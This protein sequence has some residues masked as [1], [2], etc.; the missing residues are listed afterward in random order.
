[1]A[2]SATAIKLSGATEILRALGFRERQANE[3]AAYT[4]LALLDLDPKKPWSAASNPLRGI[5]PIIDFLSKNYRVRYAPNTR[6]TIRDEAVKYFVNA[7][8]LLRNPDDAARPTN[9]GKTVYQIEPAALALIH[10]YG[11]VA[12]ADNLQ[13]YL[14]KREQIIAGVAKQRNL[15]RIPVKL[16]LGKSITLSPGG[17]N[18]LIK[19][20]IEEFC[21][22]FSPGGTVV[23]IG[24]TES[25]FL[26]YDATYLKNLGVIVAPAAKMPDVIVHDTRRNWLLL[27]EAVTSAGPVDFKRRAELKELFG[28]CK[29][30]LVFVTA[31]ENRRAMQSFAA[32]I[33]WESEV[34]IADN[35]DH[36]VHFNGER[37][38]GPYPDATPQ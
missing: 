17:Q 28:G 11:S 20:I 2:K 33:S 4:L 37:F 21:S 6:E 14:A 9:S 19:Q 7:G 1:M 38:L 5:T 35:P 34:W 8:L 15:A 32:Q 16:P 27:I 31:F 26:H 24:D 3:V 25:K 30:G 10:T 12:W 29:A 36:M 22:R 13:T 18:P 23:Y